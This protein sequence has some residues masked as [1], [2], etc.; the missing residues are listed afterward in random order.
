MWLADASVAHIHDNIKAGTI[1]RYKIH[2]IDETTIV[3]K[4]NLGMAT[5][6]LDKKGRPREEQSKQVLWDTK[7]I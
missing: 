6:K 2:E 3:V 7:I 1:N 4:K 5:P